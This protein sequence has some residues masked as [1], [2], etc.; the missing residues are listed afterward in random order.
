MNL[1]KE[2][3]MKT[4]EAKFKEYM[5]A[6]MY[7]IPSDPIPKPKDFGLTNSEVYQMEKEMR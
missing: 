6:K 4:K 1:N 2:F 7:W 3:Q 5:F